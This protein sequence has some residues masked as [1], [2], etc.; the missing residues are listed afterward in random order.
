MDVTKRYPILLS[1]VSVFILI[2]CSLITGCISE[3][4]VNITAVQSC[5]T[6]SVSSEEVAGNS[7]QALT[8]LDGALALNSSD[9]ALWAQSGNLLMNVGR[10]DEALAAYDRALSLEP[11]NASIRT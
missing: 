8:F 5:L 10:P 11:G 9:P 2:S 4:P 3:K 7:Y 6:A 1:L